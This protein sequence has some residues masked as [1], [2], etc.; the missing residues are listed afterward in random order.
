M[1]YR[2]M[3]RG[4]RTKVDIRYESTTLGAGGQLVSTAWPMRYH[5][6]PGRLQPLRSTPEFLKF[7]KQTVY[8]DYELYIEYRPGILTTDRVHY[9]E[10]VFLILKVDNWDEQ[11][12][13]LRIAMTEME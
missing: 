10:R 7:D 9:G 12:R 5:N 3:V 11:G 13:H 1:S 2:S 6:V 4:A 8:P